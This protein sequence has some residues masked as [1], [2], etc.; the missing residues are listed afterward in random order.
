MTWY[1]HFEFIDGVVTEIHISG[2]DSLFDTDFVIDDLYDVAWVRA[3]GVGDK[4]C[5]GGGSHYVLGELLLLQRRD[6]R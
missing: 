2:R 3:A 4:P 5:K 6:W 1:L